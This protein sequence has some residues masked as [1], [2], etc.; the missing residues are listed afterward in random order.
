MKGQQGE[1]SIEEGG[2][3]GTGTTTCAASDGSGRGAR[4]QAA[5]RASAVLES[6][7]RSCA[8]DCR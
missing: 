3:A 7:R 6:A 4:Q 5:E 1:R 8:A 2:R